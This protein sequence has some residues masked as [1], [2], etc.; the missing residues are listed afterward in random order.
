MAL[1]VPTDTAV[2]GTSDHRRLVEGV[3]SAGQHDEADWI[4]WKGRLD[5]SAKAGCFAVARTALGLANRDPERA[6]VTC[7]G[8]GYVVVGAEPAPFMVCG[9]LTPQRS[10]RSFSR[11]SEA[12]T[13]RPGRRCTFLSVA[14]PSPS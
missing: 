11:T 2:R 7:E 1:A 12:P 10:T 4:E 13:V 9:P 8:L 3:V 6:S 14:R 5:L